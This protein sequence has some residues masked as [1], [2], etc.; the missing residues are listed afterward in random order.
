MPTLPPTFAAVMIAFQPVFSKR[1]FAHA[2]VLVVG[3]ILAPGRRT[4]AAALRV[5]GLSRLKAYHKYHRVLSR[6][7]WSPG[8][9]ARR[10]LIQLVKRFVPGGPVVVG[11]DDT[12]ERRWGPKIKAR[13][14][15]RGHL[16]RPGA[17]QPRSFEQKFLL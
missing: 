15:Y 12:I 17:L 10:L 2:L 9:G 16:P 4:V 7:R 3:A 13:G 14:I 5:V 1:V 8:E 11:L 6:A